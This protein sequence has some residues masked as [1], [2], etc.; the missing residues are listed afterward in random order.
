MRDSLLLV[1]FVL[2]FLL[3]PFACE[4]LPEKIDQFVVGLRPTELNRIE[5]SLEYAMDR[6]AVFHRGCR[7]CRNAPV[8]LELE[9]QS[10]A[11][12]SVDGGST[13]TGVQSLENRELEP[14]RRLRLR[15]IEGGRG[16]KD[17]RL[18][19]TGWNRVKPRAQGLILD[20]FAH[21]T[22]RILVG[23][24]LALAGV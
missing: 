13:E 21:V 2:I 17:L 18:R 4:I 9:P 1:E 16:S 15:R 24:A 11:L 19:A 14:L 8:A 5:I 22:I 10:T 23:F 3:N 6:A 7:T 12:V 20:E